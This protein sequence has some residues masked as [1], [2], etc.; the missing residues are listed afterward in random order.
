MHSEKTI[1]VNEQDEPI[2]SRHRL[3]MTK[4]DIYRVSAL[5]IVDEEGRILLSR[6]AQAKS[7]HPG[8]WGPA[9]AGTV[10][11][12]ETYDSNIIKEAKEELGITIETVA[13]L[14]KRFV[15]RD[16]RHFTQWYKWIYDGQEIIIDPS[17]VDEVK[18]WTKEEI[19][20]AINSQS[21]KFLF[22][23]DDPSLDY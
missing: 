15:E 20:E 9:A 17:E 11:E 13:K 2:G 5:W 19:V 16:F 14:E 23:A 6:R 3:E 21:D 22:G 10:E 7:H 18:W 8:Y 12:N 1:L 4:D